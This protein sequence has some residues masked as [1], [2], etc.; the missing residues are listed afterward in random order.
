MC[1]SFVVDHDHST[2]FPLRAWTNRQRDRQASK[3]KVTDAT[4]DSTTPLPPAW[5]MS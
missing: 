2:I 5:V 3:H 4:D 1:T